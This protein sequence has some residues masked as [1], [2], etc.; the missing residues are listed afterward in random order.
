VHI[1]ETPSGEGDKKFENI[2]NALEKA[3]QDNKMLVLK[4]Y[5]NLFHQQPELLKRPEASLSPLSYLMAEVLDQYNDEQVLL[6]L[7]MLGSEKVE[8]YHEEFIKKL[9]ERY[10]PAHVIDNMATNNQKFFLKFAKHWPH[11][12][13][14]NA[15]LNQLIQLGK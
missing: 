12:L 5:Q 6:C 9:Y 3:D 7:E 15:M 11:F 10:S 1:W 14:N 4:K 13:K 8:N 2:N